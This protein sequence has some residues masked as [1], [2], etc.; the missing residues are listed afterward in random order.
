MNEAVFGRKATPVTADPA[1]FR[2]R[3]FSDPVSDLNAEAWDNTR[4]LATAVEMVDG[5]GLHI[6]SVEADRLRNRR[7]LV[8]YTPECAALEGVEIHRT[9][10]WSHWA[11]NRFGVEIRWCLPA[12]EVA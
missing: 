10:E 9:A 11:A 5:L 4:L 8:E 12:Q 2:S 6:L 7:I 3:R 1:V